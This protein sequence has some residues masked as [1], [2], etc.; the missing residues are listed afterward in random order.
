MAS[1]AVGF[2]VAFSILWVIALL[3]YS[4][5]QALAVSEDAVTLRVLPKLCVKPMGDRMCAMQMTMT[6]IAVLEMDVCL[7]FK[8][9]AEL[10]H[11]WQ[12]QRQG[13]IS[14]AVERE[15]NI[16]VQ[17]LNHQSREVLIELQI[18]VIERDLRETRRRRRHVWSIL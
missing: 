6:W 5:S 8:E 10:L 3:V 4:P 2:P 7:K 11:C 1:D 14:I 17:L 16:T 12:A 13:E 15:G 18:N 9:D